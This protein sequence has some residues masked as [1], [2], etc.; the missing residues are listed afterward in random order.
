MH[1]HS[2]EDEYSYVLEGRVGA[3]LGGEIVYGESGDLIFKP[4]GQWHT[5]W[6]PGD[7]ANAMLNDGL[8]SS[9]RPWRKGT[10]GVPSRALRPS[11]FY[12][13]VR[14][15]TFWLGRECAVS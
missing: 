1:R 9:S 5:F 3:D 7:K 2:R 6:N 10:G 15:R 12:I 13:A 8:R 4:R 14:T 11:P